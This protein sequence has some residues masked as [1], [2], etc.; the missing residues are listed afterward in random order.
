MVQS[1]LAPKYASFIGMAGCG[2]AMFL[3]CNYCPVSRD[4]G[5][6]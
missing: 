1:D 2:A 4:T 5:Q 6:R 3:G